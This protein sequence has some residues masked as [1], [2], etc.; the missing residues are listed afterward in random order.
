MRPRGP[1]PTP[2]FFIRGWG[3]GPEKPQPIPSGRGT[4]TTTKLTPTATT[5]HNVYPLVPVLTYPLSISLLSP[6][7]Q[8]QR[9]SCSGEEGG[10]LPHT[11]YGGG[12]TTRRMVATTM[13]REN[14]AAAVNNNDKVRWLYCLP[15]CLS[16]CFLHACLSVSQMQAMVEGQRREGWW[17][18]R[19]DEGTTSLKKVRWL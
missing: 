12:T 8:D 18:R 3:R 6:P 7:L 1:S 10:S 13:R 19:R 17:R 4:P 11:V 15:V 14:I 9:S 16:F 2:L 5:I